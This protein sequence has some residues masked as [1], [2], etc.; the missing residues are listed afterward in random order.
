MKVGRRGDEE[1]ESIQE[2]YGMM[3]AYNLIRELMIEAAQGQQETRSL[4]FLDCLR[5]I[6]DAMPASSQSTG[7]QSQDI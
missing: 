2:L 7:G 6:L 5:F 4:S 1:T 3:I